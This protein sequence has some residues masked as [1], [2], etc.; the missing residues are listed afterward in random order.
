MKNFT[1][2]LLHWYAQNQRDLP[3]RKSRD[4]YVIW[5]SEVILQQTRIDQGTPYFFRFLEAFPT[6][7][8]L[9][10]A[11][12]TDVLALWQGLGYYSRA[13]NMHQTAKLVWYDLHG[14]FPQT[15]EGLLKLKGVGPYTAAAIASIA[16]NVPVALVDGNVVRFFSRF[17]GIQEPA[18]S[19]VTKR[20]V[21]RL[22]Q[23][24]M[25]P[26]QPRAY[27]QAIMEMGSIL[28]KPIHP[29]CQICTFRSDCFAYQNNL[30]EKLPAPK[31]PPKQRHR[32][33]HYLVFVQP[34]ASHIDQLLLSKRADKDIWQGLYDFP[35]V[36]TDMPITLAELILHPEWEKRM[37][38]G[39]E[40]SVVKVGS[41][42]HLLSHQ[43][44]HAT[45]Y[46][47]SKPPAQDDTSQLVSVNELTQFPVPRLIERFLESFLKK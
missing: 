38:K 37:G 4:P 35:L 14:H 27:N 13:R 29:D 9:A 3:W 23:Q 17:F 6:V 7:K 20:E 25:E 43:V 31:R 47:V 34:D 11:T 36:E 18:D 10:E 15:Y 42:K 1:S 2:S 40:V 41:S 5:V 32:Y 26:L 45:F 30:V 39:S 16:F 33:F 22:A 46:V 12:E 21:S 19:P 28:C 24:F 8:E 44:I